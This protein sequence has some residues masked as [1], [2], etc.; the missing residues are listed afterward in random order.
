MMTWQE[1]VAIHA[2]MPEPQ[3]VS[4]RLYHDDQGRPIVY[5]MEDLP[6]NYIEIDRETYVSGSPWVRVV[7][8]KLRQLFMHAQEKLRPSDS[9]TPCHPRDVAVV[10]PASTSFWSK[11]TYEIEQD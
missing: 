11:H 1:L 8:G 7:D 3:P 5:T 10:D 2:A 4:Y 6:G 9:G